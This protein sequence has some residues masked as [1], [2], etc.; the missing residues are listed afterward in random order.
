MMEYTILA[1]LAAVAAV[2]TDL[3]LTRSC[4]VR[5]PAYWVFWF[6]MGGMMLLV[7]GY[8]TGRPIVLYHEPF[9]LGL[10]VLSLPVEDFAFGFALLTMN[11]TIWEYATRRYATDNSKDEQR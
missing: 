11:V 8:L 9:Y 7:N 5:R 10:R 1:A 4:V 3:W 2:A 6:L